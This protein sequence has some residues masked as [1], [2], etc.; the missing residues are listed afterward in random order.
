LRLSSIVAVDAHDGRILSDRRLPLGTDPVPL[1]RGAGALWTYNDSRQ[2]AIRI[3]P[4]TGRYRERGLGFAPTDIAVGAGSVFLADGVA[5]KLYQLDWGSGLPPRRVD[6]P[7]PTVQPDYYGNERFSTSGQ[8]AVFGHTVW[9]T[10]EGVSWP[11]TVVEYDAGSLR[12]VR[13]FR[14]SAATREIGDVESGPTGVWME[15]RIG[16]PDSGRAALIRLAPTP[17]DQH[18]VSQGGYFQQGVA[19][20]R[21][22]VIFAP[23]KGQVSSGRTVSALQPH[24]PYDLISVVTPAPIT[25]LA[26]GPSG[27]WAAAT[28]P[29]ALYRLDLHIDGT[30]RTVTLRHH[31]TGIAV[32]KGRVWALIQRAAVMQG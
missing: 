11:Q 9:A 8:V 32:G 31:V 18:Y 30:S 6:L 10:A 17:G 25:A 12:R 3:D 24:P 26:A 14:V 19:V 28:T 27:I 7:R 16:G 23:G 20:A 4:R 15:N 29:G 22:A 13:V 1:V 21:T 2:I 5:N